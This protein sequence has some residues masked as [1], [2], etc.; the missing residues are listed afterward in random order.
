MNH[1][2]L[3]LKVR[4]CEVDR[5][6]VVYHANYFTWFD[7]GR[8]EFLRALGSSYKEMEDRGILLVV[9]RA[10]I[11]YHRPA[12]LDDELSLT[13]RVEK[14]TKSRVH[15]AYELRRRGED[16]LLTT[17]STELAC[18]DAAGRPRR[19]PPIFEKVEPGTKSG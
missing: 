1:H 15:F 4:Y 7:L 6:D 11:R 12:R 17:G 2:R 3:D 14:L 19:L 16:L 18:L 9:V 5:Q 10:D 13:T 8:M